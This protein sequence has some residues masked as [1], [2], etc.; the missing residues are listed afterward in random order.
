MTIVFFLSRL[1]TILKQEIA[2]AGREHVMSN[3]TNEKAVNHLVNL[4]RELI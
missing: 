1:R 3:L 2:C 4:M